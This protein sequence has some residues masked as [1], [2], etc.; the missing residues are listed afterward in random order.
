VREGRLVVHA[1]LRARGAHAC[2]LHQQLDHSPDADDCSA[3]D[4]PPN[5]LGA[6]DLKVVL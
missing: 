6:V 1:S 5:L 3:A 2:T 4:L